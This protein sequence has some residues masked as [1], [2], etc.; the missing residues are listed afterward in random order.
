MSFKVRKAVK[1]DMT[2]IMGL[3]QVSKVALL[4]RNWNVEVRE[5]L[6]K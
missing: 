5:P 1:N 6:Q 2:A 4:I 3:I